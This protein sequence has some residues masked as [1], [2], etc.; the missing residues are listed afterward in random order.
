LADIEKILR[1]LGLSESRGRAVDEHGQVNNV[2]QATTSKTNVWVQ[3][4]SIYNESASEP[5]VPDPNEF[6]VAVSPTVAQFKATSDG[7]FETLRSRIAQGGYRIVKSE[8][9]CRAES[10]AGE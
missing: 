9:G 8:D 7:T 1:A 3:N 2:I 10:M 4:W 6:Y 5:L